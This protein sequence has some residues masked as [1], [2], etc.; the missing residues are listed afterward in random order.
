MRWRE[1]YR[2]D[3]AGPLTRPQPHAPARDTLE[4]IERIAGDRPTTC[5][6][7]GNSE[8]LVMDVL[9]AHNLARVGEHVHLASLAPLHLPAAVFDG[10]QLYDRHLNAVR[11]AHQQ[12]LDKDKKRGRAAQHRR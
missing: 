9:K 6:W 4:V 10:V 2:C 8:P 1:G 5:P 12:A 7:R 11:H 3:C